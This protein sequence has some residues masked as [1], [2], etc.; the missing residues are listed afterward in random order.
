[1]FLEKMEQDM[2]LEGAC[3][4]EVPLNQVVKQGGCVRNRFQQEQAQKKE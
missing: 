2:R 1:M 4:W 3:D